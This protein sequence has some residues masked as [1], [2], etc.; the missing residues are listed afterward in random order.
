VSLSSVLSAVYSSNRRRRRRQS[1]FPVPAAPRALARA[2]EIELD[3][4]AR[5][6]PLASA[7]VVPMTCAMKALS[8]NFA[9]SCPKGLS[10]SACKLSKPWNRTLLNITKKYP[11]AAASASSCRSVP[12]SSCEYSYVVVVAAAAAAGD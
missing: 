9:G 3:L 10:K 5:C 12:A 8:G 4:G 2:R 6:A 7:S 11:N 1:S